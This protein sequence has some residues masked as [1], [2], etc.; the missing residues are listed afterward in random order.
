[1]IIIYDEME[2]S[3]VKELI[4]KRESFELIGVGGQMSDAVIEMEK[5]IESQGLSCRIY[6]YGRVVSA[7]A[8]LVGGVTGLVGLASVVGMATHN[9]ATYNPDYEIAKHLVDNKLSVKYQK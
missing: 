3:N 6:T 7:S 2:L 8:T 5:I 9:L 1:M 4:D